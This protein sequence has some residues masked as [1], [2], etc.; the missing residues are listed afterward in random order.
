MEQS[1]ARFME[2]PPDDVIA[3][4][5]EGTLEPSAAEAI[6][7]HIDGCR[8]CRRLLAAAA[9]STADASTPAVEVE[10]AR[11]APLRRGATIDRYVVLDVLG[12]GGMGVVYAAY[13]PELDRRIALKLLRPDLGRARAEVRA[14][15]VREA[16]AMALLSHPNVI[17][18]HDAGSFA[19]EV[20][21]AMEL[22]TG[23]TLASHLAAKRRPV[24]EILDLFARAGAG[25]AAAHA[26]GIVHRDFKPENVLI[27]DDGRVRVTDFGL[28]RRVEDAEPPRAEGE[29]ADADGAYTTIAG[30]RL[31]T[32]AYMAPEQ[33]EGRAADARSD[34]FA[35]SVALYEALY[36]ERPFAGATMM[37]LARAARAGTVRE[38]PSGARVPTW[39]RRVLLRGLR[40]APDERFPSMSALLEAL[41]RDPQRRLR[42]GA[43]VG[44]ALV[45][46]GIAFALLRT[47]TAP[48]AVPSCRGVD[49]A[50]A[51][52]WSA[53]RKG[54][55]ERSFTATGKPYASDAYRE[56]TRA[57]DAYASRWSAARIDACEATRVRG[58]QSEQMLDLRVACL[59]RRLG[60]LDAVARLLGGADADVVE[61]AAQT[62]SALP[63][64]DGCATAAL[65]NPIAPPRG[66]EAAARLQEVEV[67][68]AEA[69]ALKM[70]GKYAEAMSSAARAVELSR[71]AG[72]APSEAAALLVLADL[73]QRDERNAEAEKTLYEALWAAEAGHSDALVAEAWAELLFTVGYKEGRVEEA[74]KIARHAEAAARRLGADDELD[75]VRLNA[76]GAIAMQ[77]HQLDVAAG[78]FERAYAIASRIVPPDDIR[79]PVLLNA[80]AVVRAERGE[81]EAALALSQRATASVERRLGPTHPDV[82]AGLDAVGQFSWALG[83]YDDALAALRRALAI[84]AAALPAESPLIVIAHGNLGRCC[85]RP[86]CGAKRSR[87]SISRSAPRRRRSAP[88]TG[89]SPS[90]RPCA[91]RCSSGSGAAARRSTKRAPRSR[92]CSARRAPV[93]R[94]LRPSAPRSPPC[95]WRTARS[96]PPNASSTRSKSSSAPRAAPIT[97]TSRAASRAWASARCAGATR[98]ARSTRSRARSPCAKRTRSTPAISPTPASP[99]P[100]RCGPSG[101]IARARWTSRA[102]PPPRTPRWVPRRSPSAPPS[103]PG[104]PRAAEPATPRRSADTTRS[105]KRRARLGID[106]EKIRATNGDHRRPP[107]GEPIPHDHAPPGHRCIHRPGP[108]PA[109]ELLDDR[110]HHAREDRPAHA[111]R[112][113]ARRDL[114]RSPEQRRRDRHRRRTRAGIHRA[115]APHAARPRKPGEQPRRLAPHRGARSDDILIP[116][117]GC[118]G[119]L[120]ERE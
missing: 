91:P 50:M 83:R 11:A 78:H 41:G 76:L 97:P 119:P 6:E 29:R 35:F 57:L 85:A 95:C 86:G 30:T 100:K 81:L 104:S 60:A 102:A 13:D 8:A 53:D 55:M 120:P 47:R 46:L 71:A 51:A 20:F 52:V 2:C 19:D 32:P 90:C 42:R 40:A 49:V 9:R 45:A 70:A 26:A 84:R 3:E 16:R 21:V 67:R 80:Q 65:A 36:G 115:R 69:K 105:P 118:T 1:P 7:R 110:P 113:R 63:K 4:M 82:A 33:H 61:R 62:V 96:T 64:L 22:V 58:E 17:T 72:Y 103:T 28:A 24:R 43:L 68:T 44:G 66:P 37:E 106:L 74:E 48:P 39:I 56:A 14:R 111:A 5:I 107:G 54:A 99:S 15:L 116:N 75:I 73:Q 89:A 108:R 34:Q 77:R 10:P 12:K 79:L 87:S 88:R 23:G 112:R 92:R 25:L 109:P 59:D 101:A 98:R 93:A 27:G 31:G 38:A 18:V 94:R 117:E 114:R